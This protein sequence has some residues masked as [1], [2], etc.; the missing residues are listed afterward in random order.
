[1]PGEVSAFAVSAGNPVRS[2]WGMVRVAGL[3]ERLIASTDWS[4]LTEANGSAV[5]VGAALSELLKAST[6][7]AI[8]APYWKI[9]NHAVAQGALFEVS[10]VCVSV[11]VAALAEE[12]PRHVRIA[13]L[14]LLFQ[15]LS[16]SRAPKESVPIDIAERC[17]RAA[18]EGLWGL[19]REAVSGERNAAWDVLDLL[20][21]QDR[22]APFRAKIDE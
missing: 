12:R 18:R 2:W 3:A 15:V 8:S 19:V 21:L 22:L 7:E 5:S 1:M 11:L 10:E 6:P 13:I 9:E 20:G 14:E 16:G 4:S 17:R